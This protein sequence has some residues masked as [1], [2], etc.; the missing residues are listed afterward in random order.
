MLGGMAGKWYGWAGVSGEG[1]GNV[2][3]VLRNWPSSPAQY[4]CEAS[5]SS[6]AAGAE[7][8][9]VASSEGGL[10]LSLLG[11]GGA[12]PGFGS[13]GTYINN[14]NNVRFLF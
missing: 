12:I 8:D 14:I 13:N 9:G 7:R 11:G 5:S 10:I 1:V 3:G 6:G 2:G 4:V